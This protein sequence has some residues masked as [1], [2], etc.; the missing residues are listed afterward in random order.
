[1]EVKLRIPGLTVMMAT[2]HWKWV[3]DLLRLLRREQARTDRLDMIHSS[4]AMV[5]S[6]LDER[7]VCQSAFAF[8][9]AWLKETTNA[10][11]ILIT[12][13]PTEKSSLQTGQ[14]L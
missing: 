12:S 10:Q 6:N 11:G 3:G 13:S 4:L 14:S 5:A 1:V 2:L 9:F 8:L 7:R